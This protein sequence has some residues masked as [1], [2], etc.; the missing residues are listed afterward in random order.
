[1]AQQIEL[2]A[3]QLSL[4]KG[5]SILGNCFSLILVLVGLFLLVSGLFGVVNQDNKTTDNSMITDN[6]LTSTPGN[7]KDIEV[8]DEEKGGE[9]SEGISIQ[10]V[11]AAT[12][13]ADAKAQE[14]AKA[15]SRTHKWKATNYVKG[16]IGIGEYTVKLGDTLWEISE[17]VYGSGSQWHKILEAN[18]NN[19][20]FL[21]NGSQA[22]IIPGQ[23]LM[24][25]K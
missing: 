1:M 6:V 10:K 5:L 21:K 9:I 19:I 3:Y 12:A 22:L 17:A 16:D 11:N 4:K 15:I 24:L 2:D 13:S 14:T 20:G 23:V 18:Q 7:V 8:I 25:N